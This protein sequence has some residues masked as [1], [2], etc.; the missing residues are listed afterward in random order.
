MGSGPLAADPAIVNLLTAPFGSSRSLGSTSATGTGFRFGVSN[1]RAALPFATPTAFPVAELP[2]RTKAQQLNEFAEV[3]RLS[4]TYKVNKN[5]LTLLDDYNTMG[6]LIL[7]NGELPWEAAWASGCSVAVVMQTPASGLLPAKGKPAQDGTISASLEDTAVVLGEVYRSTV[8]L[9]K[10]SGSGG[11]YMDVNAEVRMVAVLHVT[12]WKQ[13]TLAATCIVMLGA[14]RKLQAPGSPV[15]VHDNLPGLEPSAGVFLLSW[16]SISSGLDTR[17]LDVAR[18]ALMVRAQD[19]SL[20]RSPA[21]YQFVFTILFELLVVIPSGA[22]ER[23]PAQKFAL[24]TCA[25]WHSQ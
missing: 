22:E 5:S 10:S 14:A 19:S 11:G 13:G 12:A 17:M 1:P 20:V 2:L 8:K 18:A 15:L 7:S 24:D 6:G 25:V 9:T 16:I 4:Q 21:E 3:S 23:T